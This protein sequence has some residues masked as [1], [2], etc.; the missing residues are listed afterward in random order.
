M[1]LERKV[2]KEQERLCLQTQV[3]MQQR[4]VES[5][6]EGVA[7]AELALVVVAVAHRPTPKR[8]RFLKE[9]TPAPQNRGSTLIRNK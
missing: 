7:D 4:T 9:D 6:P 1:Q 5:A 8:H 3:V 2:S